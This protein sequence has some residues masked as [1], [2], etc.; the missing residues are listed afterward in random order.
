MGR[1]LV[2]FSVVL[3]GLVFARSARAERE[4]IVPFEEKGHIVLDQLAGLRL[5]AASGFSYAAPMGISVRTEKSDALVPGGASSET[6]TT[7][8]WLAPSADVFVTDHLSVGGLVEIN[9]SWGAVTSGGQRLELP[10]TTSM[11]FLPRIGFYAPFSDRIGLWARAGVGWTST[12]S[13]S[14]DS[15]GSIPVTQTFRSMILDVDATITYRFTEVFFMK[16]GP[17][18]G[19]TFGGRSE[20]S[21]SGQSAGA[22]SSVLQLGGAL[23]FGMNIEL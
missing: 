4:L 18:I 20:V 19:V 15:T 3:L 9:H 2:A 21:S 11:T 17:E 10:G 14:F 23:G 16:A 5:N 1:S 12:E 8:I 6:S 7:S 22:G 13:A